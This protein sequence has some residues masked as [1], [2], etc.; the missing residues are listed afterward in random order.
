MPVKTAMK[1]AMGTE[2]TP[3]R[4]IWPTRSGRQVRDIGEGAGGFEAA[5]AHMRD[6]T[7]PGGDTGCHGG[8]SHE[9]VTAYALTP[10]SS[11]APGPTSPSRS[12]LSARSRSWRTRSRVTPSMPPISSSVCSR[13]PSSPK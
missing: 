8:A 4:R 11:P 6:E 7:V 3:R 12:R 9:P 10:R 1:S 2:S 13:P 5:A